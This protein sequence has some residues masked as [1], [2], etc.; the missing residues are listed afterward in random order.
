MGA[1]LYI[2]DDDFKQE[3]NF[4]YI[5]D[6]CLDIIVKRSTQNNF[7]CL[8]FILGYENTFFNSAQM[9]VIKAEIERLYSQ[10]Q[11]KKIIDVLNKIKNA[12]DFAK[13][14][15]PSYLLFEGD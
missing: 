1:I 13:K 8:S 5:D 4:G 2:I 11:E 9:D 15:P 10:F 3:K 6:Y 14:D 7:V 12:I